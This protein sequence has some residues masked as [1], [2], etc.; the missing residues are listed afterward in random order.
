METGQ[1]TIEW[2]IDAQSYN[3]VNLPPSY[4]NLL[5]DEFDLEGTEWKKIMVV[6]LINVLYLIN[7]YYGIKIK[8]E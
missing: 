5:P 2:V 4:Q 3:G 6:P 1:D 7:A 8:I